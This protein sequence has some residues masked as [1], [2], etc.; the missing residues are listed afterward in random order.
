MPS[1]PAL[2]HLAKLVESVPVGQVARA[3]GAPHSS[4]SQLL[5]ERRPT[6]SRALAEKILAVRGVDRSAM[7]R[8]NSVGARRRLQALYALGHWRKTIVEASGLDP[9]TISRLL[10]GR[11][12]RIT[13]E[14]DEAVRRAYAQMSM[15]LDTCERNLAR[16]RRER[17]VPPLA[18]DEETIDDPLALPALDAAPPA[19]AGPHA[20]TR[21]LLGESV[22]LN[23]A[24]RRE[25][26]GYLMEWSP[27]SFE[28]IGAQLEMSGE[29]VER[30][31][32]RLKARAREAGQPV[33]TRR[34]VLTG[35]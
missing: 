34:L 23:Q 17:W 9:V 14:C 33:P 18:W 24:A 21:F 20:A 30:Q 31:W 8:V 25:V 32:E 11:W 3:A 19:P 5:V 4:L 7:S 1:G 35:T 16:A 10:G 28:E 13:I 22:V 29:A 27:R 6:M 15:S 26:I 2:A 12:A